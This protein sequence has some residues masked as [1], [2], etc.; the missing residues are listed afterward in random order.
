M[1]TVTLAEARQRLQW[2]SSP[3]LLG[4]LLEELYAALTG[5]DPRLN[6]AGPLELA[7]ASLPAWRQA[8]IDHAFATVV[9]PAL[10]RHEAQLQSHGA[11]VLEFWTAAQALCGWLAGLMHAQRAADTTRSLEAL[12]RELF[13]ATNTTTAHPAQPAHSAQ[14]VHPSHPTDASAP[15]PAGSARF[16]TGLR[17][18]L[19][20]SADLSDTQCAHVLIAGPTASGKTEW[21]R[22][23]LCSLLGANT[24]A[25]LRLALIDPQS[26]FTAVQGSPFLWNTALQAAGPA[27]LLEGLVRE[28]ERRRSRLDGLPRIVCVIDDYADLAPRGKA[29]RAALEEPL[30]RIAAAGRAAGIHLLVATRRYARELN[31]AIGRLPARVVF[32]LPDERQSRRLLGEAGAAK[33]GHGELLYKDLGAPLKLEA[34]LTPAA[35]LAAS[36][37]VKP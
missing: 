27:P 10:S 5:R 32:A 24:P 15:R 20:H 31:G 33:L 19:R 29:A 7:D 1:A 21:L 8:L 13:A 16:V 26:A 36:A 14:P 25:T 30:S 3:A 22:T 37:A 6:L 2:N 9:S 17:S 23:A 18:G 34:L 35:E 11:A 12:R 4:T 28:L